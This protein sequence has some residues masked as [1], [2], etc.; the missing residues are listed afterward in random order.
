MADVV[1]KL[2]SMMESK[3]QPGATQEDVDYI[4]VGRQI[5]NT[6]ESEYR[7]G[8]TQEDVEKWTSLWRDRYPETQLWHDYHSRAHVAVNPTWDVGD[9]YRPVPPYEYDEDADD[10]EYA[11]GTISDGVFYPESPWI[12]AFYVSSSGRSLWSTGALRKKVIDNYRADLDVGQG[13]RPVAPTEI[14]NT[15]TDE[16]SI[17]PYKM[18]SSLTANG[19]TLTELWKIG[20]VRRPVRVCDDSNSHR[21]LDIGEYTTA[22]SEVT[23]E[24]NTWRAVH[25]DDVLGVYCACAYRTPLLS[26][27]KLWTSPG[28]EGQVLVASEDGAVWRNQF[29]PDLDVGVGYRAVSVDECERAGLDDLEHCNGV[30]REGKFIPDPGAEW[31][32]SPHA[33]LDTWATGALRKR[34]RVCAD[35]SSYRYLDIHESLFE[36]CEYLTLM[37]KWRPISTRGRYPDVLPDIGY[38]VKLPTVFNPDWDVGAGFRPVSADEYDRNPKDAQF[39]HGAF[40]VDG[41]FRRSVYRDWSD[42]HLDTGADM[43]AKGAIRKRIRYTDD[44]RRYRYLDPGETKPEGYE[45]RSSTAKWTA[46]SISTCDTGG[47]VDRN[48]RYRVRVD[49]AP[50][51]K[52]QQHLVMFAEAIADVSG[53]PDGTLDQLRSDD[54]WENGLKNV[55]AV[56]AERSYDL[57][58]VRKRFVRDLEYLQSHN[59]P[60]V[61]DAVRTQLLTILD[62][63]DTDEIAARIRDITAAVSPVGTVSAINSDGTVDVELRGGAIARVHNAK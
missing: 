51:P 40:D 2:R 29:T 22:E 56:V 14:K 5:H 47:M 37:C 55:A 49:H 3:Y 11:I 33:D 48:L 28:R 26:P 44:T 42:E 4:A 15:D 62:A 60:S 1:D 30:I 53:L 25:P 35:D 54:D 63:T 45:Y 23:T 32:G 52:Q 19:K 20:H 17:D 59:D 12:P 16:F 36:G 13:Y 24:P 38:R 43:W 18:W 57:D 27:H 34:I 50:V 7:S 61:F 21:Y 39:C 8:V 9:G 31:A 10:V 58:N 6:I 46:D 41:V